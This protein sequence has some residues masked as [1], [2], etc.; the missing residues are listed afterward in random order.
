[1]KQMLLALGAV[2]A[3]AFPAHA[4]TI[5]NGVVLFN[6]ADALAGG[7]TAGDAPG[8]PVTLS[9]SGVYRLSSGLM[10]TAGQNGINVTAPEVTIDFFGFRMA[11]S[12]TAAIGINGSARALTVLNGTIRGFTSNGIRTSGEQL[13]VKNMRVVSNGGSGVY[14]NVASTAGSATIRDSFVSNLGAGVQ[15]QSGCY[16]ASSTLQK[17]SS[18]VYI[19]GTGGLV[20]GNNIS[21]NS[22]GIATSAG[23]GIGVGDNS[24]LGNTASVLGPILPLTPNVCSPAC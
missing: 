18:G 23:A 14:E 8:Y 11:G 19:Q 22:F 20:I 24:I 6:H 5:A 17:G 21:E 2:L 7:V 9:V 16:V 1:M 10:P 15:C 13:L 12:G 4:V 3:L